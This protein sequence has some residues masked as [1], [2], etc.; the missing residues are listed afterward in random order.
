[1][2]WE[3]RYLPETEDDFLNFDKPQ[4]TTILKAIKKV[5]ENPLPQNEGGYG[6]PLG[7]K[8]NR[9]LTNFLK[10]KLRSE[11][12]RIVYKLIKKDNQMLIVVIG[13]REDD[14]VYDIAYK[15]GKTHNFFDGTKQKNSVGNQA[16]GAFF[17]ML[18]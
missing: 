16:G 3:I 15:R 14:E 10:I 11:G 9:N 17:T 1:M 12:I 8:H 7:K 18:P 5:Q 6:K 2:K 13:I 4:Q